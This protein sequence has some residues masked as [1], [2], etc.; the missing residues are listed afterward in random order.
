MGNIIIAGFMG[1]GKSTVGMA[2]AEKLGLEFLDT[3][4]LIEER[5]GTT[6]PEI[7]KKHGEPFFR[8]V[9]SQIVE[10]VSR[11]QGKVISIGGG[12]LQLP[13]NLQNL[14]KE[15][16]I[17]LLTASIDEIIRRISEHQHRPLL[18]NKTNLREEMEKLLMQ[19]QSNY[20]KANFK[21][22]T[23]NLLVEGVVKEIIDVLICSGNLKKT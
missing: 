3:D 17:V 12:T 5:V 1:T 20:D 9:E 8:N 6:V 15:S 21:I 14:Q 22:D 2:L 10:E 16:I 18:A 11:E 19:R 23:T 13:D 7:F 4:V